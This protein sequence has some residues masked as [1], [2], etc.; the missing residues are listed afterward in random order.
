MNDSPLSKSRTLHGIERNLPI[1]VQPK[2]LP[3][4]PYRHHWLARTIQNIRANPI[5]KVGM[6]LLALAAGRA[7]S[8]RVPYLRIPTRDKSPAEIDRASRP[9]FITIIYQCVPPIQ[10]VTLTRL[11]FREK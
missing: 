11:I 6:V 2:S 4:A 9:V 1:V 8:G 10:R 3:L 5:T 7:I